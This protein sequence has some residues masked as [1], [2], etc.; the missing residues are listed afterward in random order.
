MPRYYLGDQLTATC[1]TDPAAFPEPVIRWWIN[2]AA[3]DAKHVANGGHF[4]T[5][6]SF[7][8]GRH[9]LT[10]EDDSVRVKC[11]VEVLGEYRQLILLCM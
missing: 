11:T 7:P 8:L 5:V 4:R 1:S 6:L 9:H 2:D 3:A 10:G